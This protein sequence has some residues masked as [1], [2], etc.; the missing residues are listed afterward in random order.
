MGE[1]GNKTLR[2]FD[3]YFGIPVVRMLGVTK[4]RKIVLNN[5]TI[6][7]AGLLKTAGIGDTVLLSGIIQDLKDSIPDVSVTIF[8]GDNNYEMAKIIAEFYKAKAIKLPVKN[9][10]KAVRIIKNFQFDVFFDFGQWSRLEAFFSYFA[11]A[12][13]KV[14]FKTPRQHRHFVY[15]ISVLHR[16]DVH[17]IDNYRAL[18]KAIGIIGKAQPSLPVQ[19]LQKKKMVVVHMFPGGVKS[20]LKEWP[21]EYWIKV[22]NYITEKGYKVLLTGGKSDRER[23]LEL[24]KKCQHGELIEVGA[25]E[26]SLKDTINRLSESTLLITVN[27]GIMHIA[28]AIGLNMIALHGPTSVKRWGPLNKNAISIQSPLSCSPCLNLGFEYGCDENKCMRAIKPDYVISLLKD[29]FGSEN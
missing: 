18:L 10:V 15:D 25:G 7:R 11:N 5:H 8:T 12:S 9:P 19:T 6:K 20:Y 3:K 14:G 17:E 2:F 27:T 21:P 23:A 29:F 28:S 24:K 22:V 16:S 4:K 13:L 1:R 26:L